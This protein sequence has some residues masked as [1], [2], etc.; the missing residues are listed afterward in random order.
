MSTTLVAP[1]RWLMAVV[2]TFGL[3]GVAVAPLPPFSAASPVQGVAPQA[4]TG[5][6]CVLLQPS[7]SAGLD[8]YIKQEKQDEKRGTD[9]ELR[10]KGETNKLERALLRF[11]LSSL[12]ADAI[13][14][15]ATLSLYVKSA[16]GGA[17]TVNAHG[18]TRAWNE[19]EVTWKAA[20]KAGC[21][22]W[23]NPGG[24]YGATVASTVL[25]D[26]K[27]VWRSWSIG[28][29]VSGWRSNPATNFGVILEA[30]SSNAE[31]VFKSSDD[32]TANQRP[33]LEVCFSAGL[34]LTPNNSGEGLA[35]Q[36]KIYP[37]VV[38]LG[39]LGPVVVSLS[40]S[41]NRGWTTLVYKD[42]NGNGVKDPADT[43][44]TQTPSIGPNASYPILVEVNI[45]VGVPLG[46]LDTT[47][48]QA[49]AGG[50]TAT[51]TDTTRVGQLLT[52][53]H[54]Y[55]RKAVPGTVQFFGHVVYNNGSTQDCV[56]I[57]ATSSQGWTVQLWQDLNRNGVHE[58]SNPN[59]PEVSNPVCLNPSQA[60]YL[61]AEVAV[62]AG[63]SPGK[64]DQT[65]IRAA[66]SAQP[67]KVSAATDTTT[68]I[69]NTPPVIDGKY[70]EVYTVSPDAQVVC[71]NDTN[72]T[73][74]GKLATFY[75]PSG[76]S[77]NS[78]SMVLAIDKDFVDN[79]YGANA[80]NWPSGHTY[81]N[82]VGSD[83]AQFLGYDANGAL[84]L[85]IKV[86]YISA[87]SGT[88]S[89]YDSLGVTGGEGRVNLGNAAHI[90]QWATSEDY[91]LNNTGYCSGGNCSGGGTNLLVDSPATD[92]FYTP[93]PTYPNWIYDVIYEIEIRKTAFGSAGFGSLEVPYIHASPS[94]LGTNT[95]YAE[96][97]VCPGEIGDTVWNDVDHDGVQDVGEPGIA[98]VQVKLYRDDGDLLFDSA[99][100]TVVGTQTTS[101]SGRYLF[102]NVPPGDFF[103]V[104]VDSTVPAGYIIT[105]N[106][107]PTPV[108][109]LLAGGSYLDA[110]F[111]YARPWGD[112]QLSKTLTSGN[113]ANVGT[114]VTYSIRITN[115]GATLINFLPLQDMYDP[116]K[117]Q[118]KS[119]TPAPSSSANGVLT[120]NDLTASFGQDLGLG[121]NFVVQLTFVALAS[122]NTLLTAAAAAPDALQAEPVVDGRLDGSYSYL[123]EYAAS[124]A[125]ATGSLYGYQG[126]NMCYWAFV[127][128]RRYNSN[129][130][131][132]SD[133][134]YLSL[135]GTTHK[136]GDLLGSD[137]MIFNV[138][139]AGGSYSNLTLDLLNGTTGAW[140]SG[141]TGK[142]GSSLPGTTALNDAMTSLHC[143]LE[144]SVVST[145]MSNT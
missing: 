84:V 34:T 15:S 55:T 130:Y 95:I 145:N 104:V 125:T 37:H 70:D 12:P 86:D 80:V 4:P 102:Q 87:A 78:V 24:D 115:V 85:D 143:N 108:F 132:D 139:Y 77:G 41:S 49:T 122:T 3:L 2:V 54:N 67:G 44:I 83:H 123:G 22:L 141:Q 100:D 105:T 58:T 92:E 103:A 79:T 133:S 25:D 63:A 45:P 21:V 101:A 140:D 59:E 118:F 129:V 51:A 14:S 110:D 8:S 40:A 134:A 88:P 138:S 17:L 27:N 113:P 112:Y 47:T 53:Q 48:V 90:L 42:V 9:S 69:A 116:A 82:L 120:W 99:K 74:F 16:S 1:I 135:D 107:N 94:K 142:D 117:L 91:D 43:Q 76:S 62:P 127:M 7:P 28:S 89:G 136:F 64:I 50:R 73:L 126:A 124:N 68:V 61:V 96:P 131:A 121:Q 119:A 71:Y 6:T 93:N 5:E 13:V 20:N 36:A 109:N 32:G 97:G 19:A 57:T 31:K 72:G 56:T 38:T 128:D 35:G 144:N 29:L 81:D 18:V 52:V 137:N 65:V 26:T 33:K 60:Y 23:T 75:Q 66:S 106:N 114:D 98:G 46:M 10:V 39:N 11:D 111:G 30:T